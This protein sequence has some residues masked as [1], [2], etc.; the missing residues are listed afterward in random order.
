MMLEN[1]ASWMSEIMM[2][3]FLLQSEIKENNIYYLQ[4]SS[5]DKHRP[6]AERTAVLSAH[7]NQTLLSDNLTLILFNLKYWEENQTHDDHEVVR[8]KTIWRLEEWT[9]CCWWRWWWWRLWRRYVHQCRTQGGWT[10]ELRT[11]LPMCQPWRNTA[12]TSW[13][14]EWVIHLLSPTLT[15][16]LQI[17]VVPSVWLSYQMISNAKGPT[18]LYCSLVY[19]AV[20]TGLF[21]VSTIFHTVAA[22]NNHG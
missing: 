18:Q 11:T 6:T 12:P 3:I 15:L 4:K 5:V 9:E 22:I 17:I 21:L 13:H 2:I 1:I 20:L 14:T 16:L 7:P 10:R 8:E 19:G